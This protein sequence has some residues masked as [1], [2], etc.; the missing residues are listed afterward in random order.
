[1][2]GD[3]LSGGIAPLMCKFVSRQMIVV[4]LSV[5]DILLPDKKTVVSVELETGW[6]LVLVWMFW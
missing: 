4:R 1:M 3:R 5:Q 2:E 6:A